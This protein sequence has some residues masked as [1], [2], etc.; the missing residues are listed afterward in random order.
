MKAEIQRI[1]EYNDPRFSPAVLRQH[2]AFLVNGVPCEVEVTGPDCAVVRG[3]ARAF[4]PQ[5][6]EDFRFYAEHISRFYDAKGNLLA[7]FSPVERFPVKL[8]DIQP[9]QFYVDK[10]KLAAVRSF[11]TEPEDVVIPVMVQDGRYISLDGHTRL[12]AALDAGFH[13]V[14]A[15]LTKG[16]DYI[17]AFAGEA[18]KRGVYDPSGLKRVSHEEYQTLWNQFCEDFLK[19]LL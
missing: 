1:N 15:F 16:G 17:L 2:G 3:D 18:R 10:D 9:S 6:I 12:A 7:G 11:V 5:L 19:Q 8:L 13:Q 14:F 4:Y